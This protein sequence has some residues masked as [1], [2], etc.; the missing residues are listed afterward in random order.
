M[1]VIDVENLTDLDKAKMEV[2]QLKKEVKLE[3][4]KVSKCCEEVMEYIQSGMDEDP[5]VKGIPEEKNPFKEKGG[6]VIC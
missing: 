5:L 4:E 6:C 1:P 2:D 3:R